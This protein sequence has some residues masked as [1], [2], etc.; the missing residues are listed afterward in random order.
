MYLFF[1]D[2]SI[3]DRPSI[4]PIETGGLQGMSFGGSGA[5]TKTVAGGLM[6]S[7]A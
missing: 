3:S 4:A 5:V 6:W 2:V 7:A 1:D